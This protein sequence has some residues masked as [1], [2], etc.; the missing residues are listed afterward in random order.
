MSRLWPELL[1]AGL[2]PGRCWL[3]R[4]S[5][6]HELLVQIDAPMQASGLLSGLDQCLALAESHRKGR[7]RVAVTVS[8]GIAAITPLPW[9]SGL[10]GGVER[11]G[12]ARLCFEKLGCDIDEAWALHV[13]YPRYGASGMAYA[14]PRD[15]MD[16]LLAG[17]AERRLLLGNVLPLS[18]R[19]FCGATDSA[20]P[21]LTIVLLFEPMH[22]CALVFQDRM[23][24]ARE[25]EPVA[26]S[27]VKTC[28]RLL[29]RILA[30]RAPGAAGDVNLLW[31]AYKEM[32]FP[33]EA[34]REYAAG[35]RIAPIAAGAWT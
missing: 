30:G 5:G 22:H 8:D 35:A 33:Q 21:G 9:Q 31:W 7:S 13:E 15:W 3:A 24:V 20:K 2:F 16:A 19:A 6:R 17:L 4:G 34:I 1:D 27:E 10:T 26:Q 14:L 12:Y 28:R 23:F 25:V 32:E 29:A 11:Q 18:A